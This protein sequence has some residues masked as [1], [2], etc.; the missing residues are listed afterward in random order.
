MKKNQVFYKALTILSLLGL[1]AACAPAPTAAPTT[2]APATAAPATAAPATA[3]PATA[4][5]PTAAPE[6]VTLTV[7]APQNAND[8]VMTGALM[9]A[10]TALHPNVKFEV[11]I[12]PGTG[13][14][15]NDMITTRLATGEMND[16]FYYNS[17][18]LL[19]AL[20]PTDTLINLAKEPFIA[21]I[22]DAFIPAVSDKGGIFGVPV[23]YAAAGGILYNKKVFAKV[24]VSVPKT[25]AEFEA[26]NEKIK[27]A[28]I[29]PV[30][31]T[32]GDSWTS[33]LLI[34]AD[35]YNVAQAIPNFAADYTA[36][37]IKY[38][39]TPAAM[40]GFSYIAEGLKKGWYQ[41]DSA[42]T[43][44]DAGLKML[45]DGTIAQYPML[46]QVMNAVATNYPDKVG[47]I[48]FFALPGPDAAHNGATVWLP[49]AFYAPKTTK[50][51]DVIMD[52]F[53]FV[54]SPAGTAAMTAKAAPAGPYLIK[55][56]KLPDNVLPFVKDLNAY[57]DSGNSYP[58]LEFLSPVKGPNL[59]NICVS[60]GTGQ[61]TP[62]EAAAAY[63]KDVEKQAKQL[64][65]PG[66]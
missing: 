54:A 16:I 53:A 50:H 15:V 48:G 65:L 41:P 1:L 40:N 28:G 39:T 13:T 36:N 37:K 17:G 4:V 63:D 32:F 44:F 51:A 8:Q 47:D 38:A 46:T 42:T 20:R 11:E 27:A 43:T 12:Q 60:V 52:F 26:N 5:P 22:A 3:A 35:F 2:I 21:N 14:E 24:G 25:W 57:I 6:P 62:A 31:A 7:L 59:P 55:G 45:A 56:A 61:M 66:W 33:Q 49:L 30:L 19:T 9:D 64:A 23:G 29:P 18:A 58:A 10:Y 34:L